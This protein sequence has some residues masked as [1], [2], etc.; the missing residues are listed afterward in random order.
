MTI[1][2]QEDSTKDRAYNCSGFVVFVNCF[3]NHLLAL[4]FSDVVLRFDFIHPVRHLASYSWGQ[5]L[6]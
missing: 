6:L 2:C 4:L 5:V 1:E 3:V